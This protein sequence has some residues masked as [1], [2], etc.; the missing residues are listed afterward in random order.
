MVDPITP[1]HPP[2]E[3]PTPLSPTVPLNPP[4]VGAASPF[5]RVDGQN[6]DLILEAIRAWARGPLRD[7]SGAWQVSLVE[8]LSNTNNWLDAW[9]LET[10]RYVQEALDAVVNNSITLQ[11]AVMEAIVNDPASSVS[12]TL[13]AR[14]GDG[15]LAALVLD[16]GSD[17]HTAIQG[18]Y[19][20][21]ER[22]LYRLWN[23]TS[24]PPRIPGSSNL[25]I[26]PV[27]PGLLALPGDI[28]SNPDTTTLSSV[29]AAILDTSSPTYAAVQRTRTRETMVLFPGDATV[30]GSSFGTSPANVYALA[31]VKGGTHS[32]RWSG[33]VP[34][35]WNT[36]NIRV[37]WTHDTG[38]GAARM[39]LTF[40]TLGPS[41]VLENGNTT[42]NYPSA[43]AGARTMIGFTNRA[44]TAGSI[45][46]GTITRISDS[47]TDTIA[48]PIG[49]LAVVLERIT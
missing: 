36:C 10:M 13:E 46:S 49:V 25:F 23:G 33:E 7:W 47:G 17:L 26:G 39:E 45:I 30:V 31:L 3:L 43:G 35:E 34:P 40:R 18:E 16:D 42:Q 32:V 21:S 38:T 24:Y 41:S 9:N 28:W 1:P 6:R 22:L 2:V 8:W 12:T 4:M 5:D 48:A 15:A 14:Y 19:R 20:I 27:N 44:V 11:D 29:T 37:Y